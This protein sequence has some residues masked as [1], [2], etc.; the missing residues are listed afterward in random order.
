MH[1]IPFLYQPTDAPFR[2]VMNRHLFFSHR[3]HEILILAFGQ[4]K[5]HIALAAADEDSPEP[6]T[7]FIKIAI[8]DGCTFVVLDNI[9]VTEK[10]ERAEK[11]L[12]DKLY[13]RVEFLKFI[14]ERC[15]GEN[16][17]IV[18]ID[19]PAARAICVS[20]FLSLCTSSMI[21][22]SV[23]RCPQALTSLVTAL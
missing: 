18:G 20:Q 6:I 22:M 5:A 11:K 15:T 10:I 13:D 2:L 12:V 3:H 23:R 9:S 4:L 8:T 16:D 14:L 19:F 1:A 7:K 17:C 21:S